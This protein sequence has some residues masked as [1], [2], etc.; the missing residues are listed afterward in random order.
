MQ[1]FDH[2][3]CGFRVP[4]RRRSEK[5][6]P[7]ASLSLTRWDGRMR[8]RDRCC[9]TLLRSTLRRLGALFAI[10]GI[11]SNARGAAAC[12]GHGQACA[13]LRARRY[14]EVLRSLWQN[15][16]AFAQAVP[17]GMDVQT[18]EMFHELMTRKSVRWMSRFANSSSLI[19]SL[20]KE[21]INQLYLQL[22]ER[23]KESNHPIA[24]AASVVDTYQLIWLGAAFFDG[25]FQFYVINA[26]TRLSEVS[27][28]FKRDGAIR[29]TLACR[30][31]WRGKGRDAGT[32]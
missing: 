3:N 16:E 13:H 27:I 24:A 2:S 7:S 23:K 30:S 29:R 9:R 4:R 6:L 26:W 10:H 21:I 11:G 17:A 32:Y 1:R 19:E 20:K 25:R 18:L 12:A 14:V 22:R 8:A 31:L 15:R 5:R 28:R